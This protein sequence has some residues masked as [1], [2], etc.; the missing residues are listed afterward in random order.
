MFN[1]GEK[2]ITS[3]AVRSVLSP[4]VFSLPLVR[5]IGKTMVQ[6]KNYG[7]QITVKRIAGSGWVASLYHVSK[8]FPK[9][10]KYLVTYCYLYLFYMIYWHYSSPTNLL[11]ANTRSSLKEHLCF[12]FYNYTEVHFSWLLLMLSSSGW[13]FEMSCSHYFLCCGI[14][15][16]Q[17]SQHLDTPGQS[18]S[19]LHSSGFRAHVNCPGPVLPT[20]AGQLPTFQPSE[21]T[22]IVLCLSTIGRA[23]DSAVLC[24]THISCTTNR[25]AYLFDGLWEWS[26][27]ES[28]LLVESSFWLI[29]SLM[30]SV[31]VGIFRYCWSV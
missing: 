14:W 9:F 23:I 16:R 22:K 4:R 11:Q 29:Q 3:P 5:T 30:S 25:F 17:S 27:A 10:G 8:I 6:G 2:A 1:C 26:T 12:I 7:P 21:N 15:Q 24:C 13:V 28:V 20:P 19:S 31:V 18:K